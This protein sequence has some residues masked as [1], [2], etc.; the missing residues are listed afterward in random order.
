MCVDTEGQDSDL[1]T[2]PVEGADV[3]DHP[4]QRTGPLNNKSPVK[5]TQARMSLYF[6]SISLQFNLLSRV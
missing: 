5:R 4:P 6:I 2:N 3:D 1:N